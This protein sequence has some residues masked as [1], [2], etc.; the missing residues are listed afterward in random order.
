MVYWLG[1]GI[2]AENAIPRLELLASYRCAIKISV[3]ELYHPENSGAVRLC[4]GIKPVQ[5]LEGTAWAHAEQNAGGWAIG[6]GGSVEITVNSE[7][8]NRGLAPSLH[9]CCR[10]CAAA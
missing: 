9:Q 8:E 10:N 3:W 1:G 7:S 6:A 4:F 2:E 5:S